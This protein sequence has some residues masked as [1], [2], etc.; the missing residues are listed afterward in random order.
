LLSSFRGIA[1]CTESIATRSWQKSKSSRFVPISYLLD[2]VF[3]NAQNTNILELDE[4]PRHDELVRKEVASFD[5]TMCLYGEEDELESEDNVSIDEIGESPVIERAA[6]LG[7][8]NSNN[9][10][11]YWDL[12]HQKLNCFGTGDPRLADIPDHVYNKAISDADCDS[13]AVDNMAGYLRNLPRCNPHR[14]PLVK[15]MS[16]AYPTNASAANRL[17]CSESL[18]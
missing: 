1:V 13:L 6:A 10:S 9:N 5:T 18:V 3:V 8:N 2:E 4:F 7:N 17:Q 14:K 11:S 16:L 15:M 12:Q